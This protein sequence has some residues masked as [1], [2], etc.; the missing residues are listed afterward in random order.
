MLV[1]SQSNS[2]L[3]GKS[4]CRSEWNNDY[5]DWSEVTLSVL[6]SYTSVLGDMPHINLHS[7]IS[8]Y[9]YIFKRIKES[10][11]KYKEFNLLQH[12]NLCYLPKTNSIKP[13]QPARNMHTLGFNLFVAIQYLWYASDC[14]K[15]K[16]VPYMYWGISMFFMM[17]LCEW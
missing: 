6:Y 2:S 8:L 10:S 9:M 5:V 7:R 11:W 13:K 12:R 16:K 3:H 14:G 15:F 4:Q 1:M 17:N